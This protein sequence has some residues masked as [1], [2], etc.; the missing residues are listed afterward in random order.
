MLLTILLVS[1]SLS[2]YCQSDSLSY[3][4]SN[5]RVT[6]D[7]EYVRRA[8]IKL[9]EHES[10]PQIIAIKDSIIH[11]NQIKFAIADSLYKA[12][13]GK[14][15]TSAKQMEQMINK[16]TKRI[17]LYGGAAIGGIAFFV[18]SILIK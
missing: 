13:Y 6:I 17:K 14:L 2:G 4:G 10:C 8:N 9:I 12:E 18:L 7:V 16:D 1:N 3:G 15:Y 11:L 5:K